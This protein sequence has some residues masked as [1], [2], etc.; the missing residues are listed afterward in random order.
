ML[1]PSVH[2]W[3][4][5]AEDEAIH[6][7]LP[8][9]SHQFSRVATGRPLH[10]PQRHHQSRSHLP[11][12]F[13]VGVRVDVLRTRELAAVENS[14]SCAPHPLN[15]RFASNLGRCHVLKKR[16]YRWTRSTSGKAGMCGTGP[17]RRGGFRI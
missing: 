7:C 10:K 9:P 14:H 17:S 16:Q 1:G 12:R 13:P 11:R 4:P 15:F 5:R 2:V 6:V 8:S 3:H